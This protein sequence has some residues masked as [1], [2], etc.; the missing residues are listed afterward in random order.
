[1]KKKTP[2]DV[3]LEALTKIQKVVNRNMDIES[4]AFKSGSRSHAEVSDYEQGRW[5]S[6]VTIFTQVSAI[7]GDMERRLK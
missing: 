5:D 1:M 7:I 2:F 6:A 3:T 4:K